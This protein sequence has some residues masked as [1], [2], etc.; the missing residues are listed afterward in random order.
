MAFSLLLSS[1]TSAPSQPTYGN[2][3]SKDWTRYGPNCYHSSFSKQHTF[4]AADDYCKS[5]NAKLVTI[6]DGQQN[7]F[8][9]KMFPVRQFVWI[10]AKTTNGNLAWLDRSAVNYT[11]LLYLKKCPVKECCVVLHTYDGMWLDE[12]THSYCQNRYS[13]ICQRSATLENVKTTPTVAVT[14]SATVNVTI[15]EAVTTEK[16]RK[17]TGASTISATVDTT[18]TAATVGPTTMTT[19]EEGMQFQIDKL[20][21]KLELLNDTLQELKISLQEG[22]IA[23]G[24]K[25]CVDVSLKKKN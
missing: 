5:L 23:T 13:E 21:K 9:A 15:V 2:N 3:C 4:S 12:N 8:L 18:T 14:E 16:V 10:G 22:Q 11:N 25:V 6:V 7:D 19:P 1:A 20:G 17:T 24:V